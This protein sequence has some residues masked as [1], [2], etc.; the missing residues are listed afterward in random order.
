MLELHRLGVRSNFDS[1]KVVRIGGRR[2]ILVRCVAGLG[3]DADTDCLGFGEWLSQDA[4]ICVTSMML[5]PQREG[6]EGL[7]E[8]MGWMIFGL[9]I[10]NHVQSFPVMGYMDR[11]R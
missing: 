3:C 1:G 11:V 6:H 8:S 9:L 10:F 2:S 4:K 5:T 7:L